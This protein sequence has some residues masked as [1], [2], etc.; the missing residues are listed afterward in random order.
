MG[1]IIRYIKPYW[2][3]AILAPIFMAIEVALELM[4]PRLIQRIIDQGIRNQDISI[5]L[6]TGL[7]MALL[8]FLALLTGIG[9][10]IFSVVTAQNV[11]A[12]LREKLFSHIQRYSFSN[13]DKSN[14]GNLI[15]ILTNDI[16]IIERIVAMGLRIM[17][18]AP[19]LIIGSI[20]MALITSY[21]LSLIVFSIIPIIIIIMYI[22]NKRVYPLYYKVQKKLDRVNTVIQENLAG[23][24]VVKA[25]VR[26]QYEIDRFE[27][28]NKDFMLANIT[29]A[30]IMAVVM[31][32]I[33]LVLNMGIVAIIW[34]GGVDVIQGN[35]Q[36][37]QIV[38]F[39]NYL[40]RLLIALT[41]V[42]MI[43][44]H[45]SRSMASADRI[46]EV[47]DNKPDIEEKAGAIEA[48]MFAGKIEFKN[49]GF[50]Y[51]PGKAEPVLNDLNLKIQAGET[52]ALIGE[53]GSGKSSLI[54]LIPRLYEVTSGEI[55]IDSQNI[56]NL[57]LDSLRKQI[58][59]VMQQTILFSGPIKD[60]ISYGKPEATLE[61]IKQA[62]E[63]A[64]AHEF[65]SKFK[66]GYNTVLG[67]R[68]INLSGGQKQ[69]L[70][71]ARALLIKPAILILDSSTSAIDMKTEAL[72]LE[73]LKEVMKSSTNIV[74]AQRLSTVINADKI[75]VLKEGKIEGI[76]THNSLIKANS[77]YREIYQSQFG[78][79]EL[80]NA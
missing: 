9:C 78:K 58:G 39:I 49:V 23:I 59:M 47:L 21:R 50:S 3:I 1:R 70:A 68:G 57:K 35:L 40:M 65:I 75:I 62:A 37:G 52:V 2:K 66:D 24:R 72:I 33:M 42:S 44:I 74:I 20:I 48:E 6:N 67:Q 13:L 64:Q 31:P 38:A 14:T 36:L 27:Q 43:F 53:T 32:L 80:K 25:F 15:T 8:A 26:D 54:Q 29:A 61:E 28:A 4:Q 11:A 10:S 17:V 41:I 45:F 76:G 63:I 12:D 34:F 51:S 69:R 73:K 77:T 19:L 60:N 71:I 22:I 16:S 55:L 56:Q 79:E 5:I 7:L 46:F 30:R 18:R